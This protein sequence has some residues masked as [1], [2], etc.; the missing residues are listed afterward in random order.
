MLFHAIIICDVTSLHRAR[1]CPS[2]HCRCCG[3]TG[4]SYDKVS[5]CGAQR[6]GQCCSRKL[7]M[8]VIQESCAVPRAQRIRYPMPGL[9]RVS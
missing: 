5:A 8:I 1:S 2:D 4:L 6:A 9:G 7:F 3:V